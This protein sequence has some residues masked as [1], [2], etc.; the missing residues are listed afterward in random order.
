MTMDGL[1]LPANRANSGLGEAKLTALVGK[2]AD[3]VEI[4]GL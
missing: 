2:A 4:H 3:R 1:E